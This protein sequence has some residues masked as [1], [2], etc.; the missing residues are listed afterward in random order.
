MWITK[1]EKARGVED[2][3]IVSVAD[4]LAYGSVSI[5]SLIV[6]LLRSRREA[7]FQNKQEHVYG[8]T[9]GREGRHSQACKIRF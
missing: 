6:S 2:E 1:I 4:I 7:S 5:V 8:I 9:G 3:F